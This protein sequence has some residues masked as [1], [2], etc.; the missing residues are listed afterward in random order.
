MKGNKQESKEKAKEAR[1]WIKRKKSFEKEPWVKDISTD[2]QNA[3]NK[4]KG[5]TCNNLFTGA[6][7]YLSSMRHFFYDFLRKR[8]S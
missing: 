8:T 2:Q 7:I 3:D 6:A 4:R 1:V 5:K